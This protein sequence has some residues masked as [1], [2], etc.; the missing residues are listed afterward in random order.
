MKHMDVITEYMKQHPGR[1]KEQAIADLTK[2]PPNSKKIIDGLLADAENAF[3]EKITGIITTLQ[4]KN[5]ELSYSEAFRIEYV[6]LN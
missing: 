4:S 2:E 6:S 3:S 1:T 5:P